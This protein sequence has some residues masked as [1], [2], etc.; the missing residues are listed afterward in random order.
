MIS[1]P[2]HLPGSD[3]PGRVIFFK[4]S[5]KSHCGVMVAQTVEFPP[6]VLQGPRFNLISVCVEFHVLPV[7]LSCFL[8]ILQFP[9][10]SPKWVGGLPVLILPISMDGC[11]NIHSMAKSM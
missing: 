3:A 9:P 7:F 10:S 4:I 5:S 1:L 11:M 6:Q 2:K 8:V